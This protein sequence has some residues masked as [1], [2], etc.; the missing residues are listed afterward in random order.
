MTALERCAVALLFALA[1]ACGE[2]KLPPDEAPTPP[3]HVS[4]YRSFWFAGFKV[5]VTDVEIT[6][7]K[8]RPSDAEVRIEAAFGNQSRASEASFDAP[9]A[10]AFPNGTINARWSTAAVAPGSS[11]VQ[12]LTILLPGTDATTLDPAAMVLTVGAPAVQQA[13]V[14]LGMGEAIDRAPRVGPLAGRMR[15]GS[16]Q[17]DVVGVERRFDAPESHVQLL[18]HE[19]MMTLWVYF[20]AVDGPASVAPGDLW[21]EEPSGQRPDCVACPP[22]RRD[23]G[24]GLSEGFTMT[25]LVGAPAAGTFRLLH[26]DAAGRRDAEIPFEMD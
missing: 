5:T 10:L 16:V 2:D 12:S 1:G 26:L 17:I 19:V 20:Q 23:L 4:L 25:F 14:P 6:L 11:R 15:S 18:A 3:T 7:S 8:A 9:V 22:F 21:L 24:R 13:V